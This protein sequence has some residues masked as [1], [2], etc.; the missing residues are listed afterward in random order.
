MTRLLKTWQGL[1]LLLLLIATMGT[2]SSCGDDEPSTMVIDYYLEIEEGFLVDGAVDHTDRYYSPI[3][4][5]WEVIH[6]TYPTPT[7]TG[8]DEAVIQACDELYQ[9]YQSMYT[10]KGEHLTCLFHLVKATKRGD[11]IKQNEYLKTY[12]FDINPV[13]EEGV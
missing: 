6:A 3:T 2:L 4:L 12:A 8:N 13:S 11:I 9:R 5:M 7:T 10:G 1:S